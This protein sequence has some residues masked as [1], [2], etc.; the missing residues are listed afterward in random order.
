MYPDKQ[1][2]FF[3]STVLQGRSISSKVSIAAS[4]IIAVLLGAAALFIGRQTEETL[5][6]KA[7][8]NLESTVS[9]V[10]QTIE[11]FNYALTDQANRLQ[12]VFT[13]SFGEAFSI[14]TANTVDVGG[15]L[16]PVLRNGTT[17]LNLNFSAVDRF[18]AITGGNAT[19]FV[20]KGEDFIRI[21]TSVKKENGERAVGTILDHASPAYAAVTKGEVFAGKVTLFGKEFMTNYTPIKD[22]QGVV[23]AV[24]YIGFDFTEA[25]KNLKDQIKSIK[26]GTTGYV[27]AFDGRSGKNY[28]ALTLHPVKEGQNLLEAKDADGKEFVKEI[29]QKKKGI[30][31][32]NWANAELNESPRQKVAVYGEVPSWGWVIG[33]GSYIDEFNAEGRMLRNELMGVMALLVVILWFL[34]SF[35]INKLIGQPLANVVHAL[36]E[37][38]RGNYNHQISAAHRGD[39]IGQLLEALVVM[40]REIRTMIG[41]IVQASSRLTTAAGELSDGSQKVV[42]GSREQSDSAGAMASAIEELTISINQVA[43]NAQEAHA[44]S[45]HSGGLCRNGAEIIHKAADEMR[46]I[47]EVVHD[48]SLKLETLGQQSEQVASIINIIKEIADQ[49]NLLA[50]NAAIEAARAGEQGRGFAVVADEVR[51]LSERTAQST[52]EISE[53]IKKMREGTHK[54]V[55]AMSG[56]VE[57][58]DHGVTLAHQA[59]DSITEIEKEASRVV[60]VVSQISSAIKEQSAAS[61]GVAESVERIAKMAERNTES[62]EQAASSARD[63]EQLSMQLQASVSNFKV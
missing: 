30:I 15:K 16:V 1:G 57:E 49:T 13:G 52:Q 42:V 19:V 34:I 22:Q 28:G 25:F 38:A 29:L 21:T 55:E 44:A 51:K 36:K 10:V 18:S 63:L 41:N 50:L 2:M 33:A 40:Q 60:N 37:M 24:L 5:D 14:D 6:A 61:H 23:I 35:T 48:C 47:A 58:V 56:A 54:I 31:H 27:Y 8:Q 46:Q 53:T 59:G 7:M 62:V 12:R 3:T 20:R 11:T 4:V 32:Y 17:A 26:I 43:D 9:T 39:E 45:T